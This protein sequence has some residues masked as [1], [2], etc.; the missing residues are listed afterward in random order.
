MSTVSSLTQPPRRTVSFVTLDAVQFVPLNCMHSG[1][2][3]LDS[4]LL[5]TLGPIVLFVVSLVLVLV[6]RVLKRN[7]GKGAPL[8]YLY[9]YAIQLLFLVLPTISRRIGQS[10]Q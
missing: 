9:S 6:H 5:E 4:L 7:A 10:L 1:F 2:D 3:H 8:H